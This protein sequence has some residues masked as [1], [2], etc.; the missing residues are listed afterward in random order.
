M[1]GVKSRQNSSPIFSSFESKAKRTQSLRNGRH[2]CNWYKDRGPEQYQ[3]VTSRENRPFSKPKRTT[4]WK[5]DT[6]SGFKRT[7]YMCSV[8]LIPTAVDLDSYLFM[9]LTEM[10]IALNNCQVGEVVYWLDTS[11]YT[12]DNSFLIRL[13]ACT[14][15]LSVTLRAHAHWTKYP[16]V[17]LSRH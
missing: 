8:E 17:K 14:S 2:D 11:H 9:L 15:K 16:Q 3:E 4:K 7:R 13:E 5:C 10:Y 6:A 12:P 1:T